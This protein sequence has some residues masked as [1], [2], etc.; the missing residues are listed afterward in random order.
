MILIVSL[1][2]HFMQPK[3]LKF[4]LFLNMSRPYQE[5]HD[6]TKK[7][8]KFLQDNELL[9][10]RYS[11]FDTQQIFCSLKRNVFVASQLGAATMHSALAPDEALVT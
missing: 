9:E 5:V 7:A 6:T 3:G 2:A 11:F 8:L 10:W 1:S 4:L